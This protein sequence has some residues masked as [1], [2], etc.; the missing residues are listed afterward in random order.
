VTTICPG[1]TRTGLRSGARYRSDSRAGEEF[2][3][4]V[5]ERIERTEIDP[6]KVARKIQTAVRRNRALVRISPETY[7]LSW[8]YRFAPGLFRRVAQVIHRRTP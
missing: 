3:A 5:R 4:G 8:G 6:F 1:F 7:L 2:L